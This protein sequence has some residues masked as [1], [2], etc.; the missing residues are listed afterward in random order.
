[1]VMNGSAAHSERHEGYVFQGRTVTM[2]VEVR[3]A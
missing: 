1:M 2:P 3:D